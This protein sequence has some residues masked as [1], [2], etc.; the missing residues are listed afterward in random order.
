MAT[1]EFNQSNFASEVIASPIAVLVDFWAPWCGP[2]KALGPTIDQLAAEME[3]KVK[4]G[5][6]NID[7]NPD[8]AARYSVMSIPT[9]LLF[10]KG[11]VVEQLVGLVNKAKIAQVISSHL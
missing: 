5:K 11:E 10:V 9:L 8:L 3:G 2:C 1:K 6:L 4:I 7:E